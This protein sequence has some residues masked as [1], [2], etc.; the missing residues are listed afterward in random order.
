[1]SDG[2]THIEI[3][4]RSFERVRYGSES[5]DW[6]ADREPIRGSCHDCGVVKG[7]LHIPGCGV[8]RCPDCGS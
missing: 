5:E 3:A 2:E 6:G 7:E 8:E 4:A 1:M